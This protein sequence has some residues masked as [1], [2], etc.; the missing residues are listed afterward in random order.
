[1]KASCPIYLDVEIY[2]KFREKHGDK[3]SERIQKL[4]E[5]DLSIDTTQ[6]MKNDRYEEAFRSCP[7]EEQTEA[8]LQ[9]NFYK[10]VGKIPPLMTLAE[11]YVKHYLSGEKP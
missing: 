9:F 6:E 11:Y 2:S 8:S 3:A 10:E 4:L 5:S 7:I 1:M